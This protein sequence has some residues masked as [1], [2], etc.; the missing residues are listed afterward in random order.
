[1]KPFRVD[2]LA[3]IARMGVSTLNH[4]FHA[5]TALS[6]VCCVQSFRYTNCYFDSILPIM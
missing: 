6:P 5:S 2:Q 1:M 3:A 4:H